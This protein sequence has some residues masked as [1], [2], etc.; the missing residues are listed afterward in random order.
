M[1]RPIRSLAALALAT[2]VVSGAATQ[3][4]PTPGERSD[5]IFPIPASLVGNV[6]FWERVFGEWTSHQVILHDLRYPEL[7]YEVVALP[8]AAEERYTDIQKAFVDA[9][10]ERWQRSIEHL[11]AR[12]KAGDSLA[13]AEAAWVLRITEICGATCLSDAHQRIRA[14]RGMRDR[15]IA[16]VERSGRW[17]PRMR[18]IFRNAGLPED[19][20]LLPHVESSFTPTARSSAAAVGL[21]QFTRPAGLRFMTINAS[22]DERLDPIAATRGAVGYLADAFSKL[23]NWPLAITSYNHGVQGMMRAAAEHAGDP[24]RVFRH[25]DGKYFGFASRNFYAEFLAVCN[26]VHNLERYFPEGVGLAPPIAE[27]HFVLDRQESPNVIARNYGVSIDSLAALNPA[28]SSR[29]F[30]AGRRL[31][32]GTQVW[33]P[34]GTFERIARGTTV[35]PAP[36]PER[37]LPADGSWVVRAGDTLASIGLAFGV[38]PSVLRT[39]NDLPAGSSLIHPGQR[40]KVQPTENEPRRHVVR[41]GDS[42]ALIARTYRVRLADLM[43]ENE[44][45]PDDV[46]HPG[47][48]LR[49]P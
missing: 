48:R 35:G 12:A 14:Q 22:I 28:W 2:A 6:A 9:Q 31:P 1:S 49:I 41:R 36:K 24:D 45:D 47:Q 18:E 30:H 27:D 39:W 10:R 20:T 13:E 7:I 37:A 32:A 25:Y 15:F 29:A 11:V 26:I 4:R 3:A 34:K 5:S 38:A 23:G 40:L 21:W 42:L 16:G 8:G 46:I 33:L 44:L 43:S 19:L 17:L